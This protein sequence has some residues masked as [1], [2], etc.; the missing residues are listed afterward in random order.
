MGDIEPERRLTG[1]VI[2][3]LLAAIVLA[4]GGMGCGGDEADSDTAGSD[5][6]STA[7]QERDIEDALRDYGD[8]RGAD[9][10]EFVTQ[11]YIDS[12]GGLSKCARAFE[13]STPTKYKIQSINVSGTKGSARG[14]NATTG[15]NFSLDLLLED[16]EWKVDPR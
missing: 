13:D 11:E 4:L 9:T 7:S 12:E 10:C 15:E 2:V 6:P 16:G 3:G 14:K 8:A 1:K 5:E